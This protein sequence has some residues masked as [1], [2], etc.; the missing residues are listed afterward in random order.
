MICAEEAISVMCLPSIGAR[1]F[2][3]SFKMKPFFCISILLSLAD[4]ASSKLFTADVDPRSNRVPRNVQNNDLTPLS[5][6]IA[7]KISSRFANTLVTSV[8]ENKSPTNQE[9]KFVVQLPETAFISNFSMVVDGKLY[10]GVVKEKAAAKKEYEKAK[11]ESL[12]TGLVS[13]SGVAVRGMDLFEIAFNVA[14]NSTAEFRLNYQQ[15]LQRKKGYFEQ[16][17]SVRPKKIVP[18]LKV[19]VDIEEPQPLSYVDVMKI[20]KDPSDPLVKGNPLAVVKETSP[21]SVHIEY[22]PSEEKQGRGGI[23]GDFIVR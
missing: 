9:T 13:Q 3:V 15:L 19:V 6:Q 2:S 8:L 12:N 5:L 17:I 16:V 18:V 23:Y 4:L 21:K 14:P 11:N 10:I 7:S 1:K 20:R 22:N